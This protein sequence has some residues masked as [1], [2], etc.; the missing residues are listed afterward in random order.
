MVAKALD[1]VM[2]MSEASRSGSE[3][4]IERFEPAQQQAVAL[5]LRDAT[6]EG[7]LVKAVASLLDFG[8]GHP[9]LRGP[10]LVGI[11][12]KLGIKIRLDC[13]KS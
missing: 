8:V 4:M 3:R 10:A 13:A 7:M 12:C 11:Y 1:I 6:R 5:L 2:G 9:R